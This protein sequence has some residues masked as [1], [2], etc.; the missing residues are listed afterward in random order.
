MVVYLTGSA[1][2][3]APNDRT[4]H[5]LPRTRRRVSRSPLENKQDKCPELLIIVSDS[6]THNPQQHT[7]IAHGHGETNNYMSA[8]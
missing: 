7:R 3:K 8:M 4:A 2:F 5:D 6:D 1:E